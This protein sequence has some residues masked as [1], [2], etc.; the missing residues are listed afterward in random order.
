M[1]EPKKPWDVTK[2]VTTV[3]KTNIGQSSNVR[4]IATRE[5][6]K[7]ALELR[8]GGAT[9]AEIA[10]TLQISENYAH[11]IVK[12][13]L[14]AITQDIAQEVVKLELD[15]LDHMF[16]K[17]YKSAIAFGDKDDINSC[18]KIMERRAKYLGLDEAIKI[19]D[20]TV[21]PL[22][23]PGAIPMDKWLNFSCHVHEEQRV[24]IEIEQDAEKCD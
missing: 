8:R 24:A 17:P 14:A 13:A 21:N 11:K 18:L 15:R 7:S 2:S 6:Q 12:K 10:L 3:P 5:R 4:A 1:A 20:V 16:E 19:E 23:V 9:Y 22:S